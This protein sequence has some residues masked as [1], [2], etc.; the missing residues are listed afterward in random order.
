M[1]KV[2]TRETEAF[3][4]QQWT[5]P[6][7]ATGPQPAL[8]PVYGEA[9]AAVPINYTPPPMLSATELAYVE[10][11]SPYAGAYDWQRTVRFARINGVRL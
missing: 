3:Y 1:K 9:L 10:R 2:T 7:K 4:A 8:P 6:V 5:D 11:T